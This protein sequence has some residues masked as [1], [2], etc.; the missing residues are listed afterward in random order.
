MNKHLKVFVTAVLLLGQSWVF[1]ADW[2]TVSSE[3]YTLLWKDLTFTQLKIDP[4]Q[5]FPQSGDILDPT[6]AK[7]ILIEYKVGVS[8]ERFRKMTNKALADAFSPEELAAAAEDIARFCTWYIAVEKGDRYQLTWLPKE[9]L[10][11]AMNDAELGTISSSESASIILSVWL[12]R[13]AVSEDQRD[14]M[15]AAWRQALANNK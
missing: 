6:Y 15:L 11:L 13:A 9:G 4:N 12:G 14:T 3:T 5:A 8:A 10:T 7:Q 2:R 1:A